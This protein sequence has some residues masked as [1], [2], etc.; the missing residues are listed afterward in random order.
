MTVTIY[1]YRCPYCDDG[2]MGDSVGR[3]LH[4]A[5]AGRITR[6]DAAGI[7]EQDLVRLPVPPG[8]AKRACG[9]CA[10]RPGSPEREDGRD[11]GED[12]PFWCHVGMGHAY[13]GEY[14]PAGFVTGPGGEEFPLGAL[15][16]AGWWAKAT[17]SPMP[18]EEFRDDSPQ[19]NPRALGSP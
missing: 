14:R 9:G 2:D 7:P 3:C 4:C 18:R 1:A 15:V 16:C 8:V 17:G 19:K 13:G 12:M 5:G 6:D 10:T 11:P